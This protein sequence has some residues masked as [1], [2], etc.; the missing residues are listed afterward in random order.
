MVSVAEK[1]QHEP[2]CSWFL[3]GVTTAGEWPTQLKEVG[4]WKPAATGV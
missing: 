4:A 2:H 1:A 3:I